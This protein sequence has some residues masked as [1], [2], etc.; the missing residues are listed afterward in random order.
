[1]CMHTCERVWVHPATPYMS[2]LAC[3][4]Y[5]AMLRLGVCATNVL[6]LHWTSKEAAA[7][8]NPKHKLSVYESAGCKV[9]SLHSCPDLGC[10][11]S[12]EL[13]K[14]A[15]STGLPHTRAQR[16][17]CK[18]PTGLFF[19]YVFF[20]YKLYW[21]C[22]EMW[23]GKLLSPGSRDTHFLSLFFKADAYPNQGA[24]PHAFPSVLKDVFILC[25]YCF[26][27]VCAPHACLVSLKSRR[28]HRIPEQKL[29]KGVSHRGIEYSWLLSQL[30]GPML[31]LLNGFVLSHPFSLF[32]WLLCWKTGSTLQTILIQPLYQL[33][34]RRRGTHL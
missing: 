16:P 30:C 29:W 22:R 19:P 10:S 18:I 12:C 25:A 5:K 9:C 23:Q 3:G 26:T 31:F 4:H 6:H 2:C 27:L 34:A 32:M 11:R 13:L 1:M 17:H 8:P 21:K 7:Q 24:A 14:T 20:L 33:G 28:R 15:S